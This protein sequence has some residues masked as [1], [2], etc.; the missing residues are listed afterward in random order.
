MPSALTTAGCGGFA[1]AALEPVAAYVLVAGPTLV[2]QSGLSAKDLWALKDAA[3]LAYRTYRT[4]TFDTTKH[5][6]LAI[7]REGAYMGPVTTTVRRLVMNKF[8]DEHLYV[9]LKAR[10][11]LSQTDVLG[12]AQSE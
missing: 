4:G 12:F 10:M 3:L 11:I 6:A 2:E 7:V 8:V 1:T 5:P 9:W